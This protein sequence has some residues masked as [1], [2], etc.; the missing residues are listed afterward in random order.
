MKALCAALGFVVLTS[1][2]T[3]MITT[4]IKAAGKVATTSIGVAGDVASAGV[5]AG[6]KV[7]GSAGVD[8]ELVKAAAVLA[9]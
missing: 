5:K 3:K 6:G 2:C 4:P 8:P 1:G 9:K 7:A